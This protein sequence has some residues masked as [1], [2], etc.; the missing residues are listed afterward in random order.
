[1]LKGEPELGIPSLSLL[2]QNAELATPSCRSN[3]YTK[4]TSLR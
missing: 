1:V 3:L 4:S 2:M